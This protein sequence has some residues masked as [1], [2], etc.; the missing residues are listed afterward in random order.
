[1]E[2]TLQLQ[3]LFVLHSKTYK[4]TSSILKCA[5]RLSALTLMKLLMH[6]LQQIMLTSAWL[7]ALIPANS[8]KWKT[9]ISPASGYQTVNSITLPPTCQQRNYCWYSRATCPAN[10]ALY[11]AELF[12]RPKKFSQYR[13]AYTVYIVTYSIHCVSEKCP[14]FGLL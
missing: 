14:T 5:S 1:M 6:L 9:C 12:V 2:Q 8:F 4:L 13:N 7:A 11:A 10:L 3:Q